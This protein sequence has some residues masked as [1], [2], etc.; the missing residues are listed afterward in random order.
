[1]P[2]CDSVPGRYDAAMRPAILLPC[3]S[4]CW[5]AA[6]TAECPHYVPRSFKVVSE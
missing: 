1:V 6:G 5:P 4:L 2:S 3:S